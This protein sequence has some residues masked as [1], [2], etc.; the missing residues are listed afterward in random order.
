LWSE[1]DNTD[2]SPVF[3][4]DKI[5]FMRDTLISAL[6]ASGKI[7]LEYFERPIETILKES[8]SSI[9]TEADFKSD[10]VIVKLIGERF[11]EHNIISE[12]SGFRNNNSRFTWVIDPLD[13]TSNFASA[14]PWFGV[15]ISL[16]EDNTPVMGGAYL[17]VAGLLYFAEKGKGAYRN[18]VPLTLTKEMELRN[19]LIA[20]SVDYTEDDAF[21][22]RGIEIY[23]YLIKSSRNIR[24]TNSLVDFIYVAEGKFGGCINLFT[25]VWDISA[26][27]LIIT[28]SGGVMVDVSGKEI[29][30]SIC[31][32]IIYKNFPVVAGSKTI[33]KQLSDSYCM[34]DIL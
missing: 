21:L 10:A 15:L 31:D 4:V 28:E 1:R 24:S 3:L 5:P 25:R 9:V 33:L 2:K 18:G 26:L 27:S 14:I 32:E 6:K 34:R 20:F 29:K 23:K 22:N 17:P 16:L 13:G 30:Y 11:P 7:L 12:E 19:S 8:Q